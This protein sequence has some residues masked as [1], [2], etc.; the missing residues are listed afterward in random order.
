MDGMELVGKEEWEGSGRKYIK[1]KSDR[2][3]LEGQH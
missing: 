2:K 3:F 1:L